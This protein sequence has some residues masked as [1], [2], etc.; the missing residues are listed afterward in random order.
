MNNNETISIQIKASYGTYTAELPWDS[1]LE[2]MYT[3]FKGLLVAA[4]WHAENIDNFIIDYA[5]DIEQSKENFEE[6]LKRE[7]R[8]EAWSRSFE[9]N[10]DDEDNETN[11]PNHCDCGFCDSFSGK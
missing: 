6:A 3:S 5:S 11:D 1:N 7:S 2:S 10:W 8:A 4:T 9:D